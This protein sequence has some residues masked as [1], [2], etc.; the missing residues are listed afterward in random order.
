VSDATPAL[1]RLSNEPMENPE[2]ATTL[3]LKLKA[4]G[5]PWDF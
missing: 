3:A 4:R 1:T 5:L 2:E